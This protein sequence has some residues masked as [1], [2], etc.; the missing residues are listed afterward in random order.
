MGTSAVERRAGVDIV[1]VGTRVSRRWLTLGADD[2]ERR[3]NGGAQSLW[4]REVKGRRARAPSSRSSCPRYP[5]SRGGRGVWWR[6]CS[7]WGRGNRNEGISFRN[8]SGATLAPPRAAE[9]PG[10]FV[11]LNGIEPSAS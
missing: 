8:R 6:E 4:L 2:E 11:E 9:N 10:N 7:T 5:W 1:H 3:R